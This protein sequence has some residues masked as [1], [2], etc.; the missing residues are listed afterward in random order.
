MLFVIS[1]NLSYEQVLVV[2]EPVLS[3]D[4]QKHIACTKFCDAGKNRF[5]VYVDAPCTR[6]MQKMQ[7]DNFARRKKAILSFK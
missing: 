1:G 7:D 5:I 6:T 3:A 2:K 4:Q